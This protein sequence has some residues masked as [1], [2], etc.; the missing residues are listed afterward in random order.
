MKIQGERD[1]IRI[2]SYRQFCRRYVLCFCACLSFSVGSSCVVSLPC[3]GWGCLGVSSVSIFLLPRS[4][5]SSPSSPPP[6]PPPPPP[7]SPPTVPLLSS[8]SLG[9]LSPAHVTCRRRTSG[10]VGLLSLC[11]VVFPFVSWLGP[12]S[13]KRLL[14]LYW[15]HSCPM[16]GHCESVVVDLWMSVVRS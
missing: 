1:Q 10:C 11:V 9:S 15:R 16:G 4:F 6:P 2:I 13:S 14:W 8:L 12:L 3:C 7:P 5:A